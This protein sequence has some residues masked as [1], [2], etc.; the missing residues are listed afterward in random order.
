M[1]IGKIYGSRATRV[2][3]LLALATLTFSYYN[4]LA[5]STGDHYRWKRDLRGYYNYLGRA[6][7]QGQLHLPME[8]AKELLALKNPWDPS[9]NVAWRL[10]D[11]VLYKGRYYLYHG[12][13]PAIV[14]FAPWRILTG[15]DLPENFAIVLLCF[16]A[17]VFLSG[18]LV[19]L[20][21][22]AEAM[23]GL[24]LLSLML[25]VL[26][27]GTGVPYLLIRVSVYELAIAG[28]YFG[29]AGGWF[30]VA[31]GLEAR[32]PFMWHLISGALFGI[33]MS[34]RPHVGIAGGACALLVLLSRKEWRSILA[35][36]APVVLS[37]LAVLAYNYARFDDPFEFGIHYL[38]AGERNQQQ[39]NPSVDNLFPGVYYTLFC[40]P[41]VGP[42]FPFV[43]LF[44]RLPF[45]TESLPRDYFFEPTVGALLTSPVLTGLL[46]WPVVRRASSTALEG[47][48][49]TAGTAL[50]AYLFVI[51]IGF[52]TQRYQIDYVPL[53]VF[54]SLVCIA[55]AVRQW[56]GAR[57]AVLL[58]TFG[59]LSVWTIFVNAGLAM[60]GPHDE[61]L[62][63]RPASWI[64]I[65]R[66]FSFVDKYTP[67]LDPR[68]T[69]TIRIT[70]QNY[71][72]GMREPLIALGHDAH[73]WMLY[74]EH[75]EQGIR[76]ASSSNVS[77]DHAKTLLKRYE[78][79]TVRTEYNPES[80]VMTTFVNGE[81]QIRHQLE[82][83]VLT[84]SQ[85]KL[86]RNDIVR[87]FTHH[88]FRGPLEVLESLIEPRALVR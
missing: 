18:A 22:Q 45:W 41:F 7:A 49:G 77:S 61:I 69:I 3:V 52:T 62:Q 25:L 84:R 46:L 29:V 31:R 65:A 63:G 37:G 38:L 78:E 70:L 11:G 34:S 33:A 59:V 27:V 87:Y 71:G 4:W 6:F 16:G 36:A 1:T 82:A 17:Y 26:A 42:E 39:L 55:T 50:G 79:I 68:V 58:I 35:L 24:G 60:S 80:K 12:A 20:L 48:L 85:V 64:R 53:M 10:H 43:R 13:G 76:L 5:R 23:P 32:R 15:Y 14:L 73:R 86:G 40:P 28:A 30:C 75:S 47:V 8:P 83:L 19:I 81:A 56:S 51:A 2:F 54:S 88:E 72:D 9:A 21:R 67:L 66:W 44:T 74:V 57:R